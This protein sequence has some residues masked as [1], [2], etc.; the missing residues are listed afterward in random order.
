MELVVVNK[1]MLLRQVVGECCCSCCCRPPKDN[2]LSRRLYFTLHSL[3][4]MVLIVSLRNINA[5]SL[6]EAF[7]SYRNIKS[8]AVN[9]AAL[10]IRKL[11]A[12][13]SISSRMTMR[14]HS[15]LFIQQ[16][17]SVQSSLLQTRWCLYSKSHTDGFE[18]FTRGNQLR[19][20]MTSRSMTGTTANIPATT[21]L[22]VHTNIR[23]ADI[24]EMLVGGERYS[25]VP[26][27]N[28]M[29]ATTIFVGNLCEFVQDSD[30]STYFSQVSSLTSVPSCV[31]RKVD[32][33]SMGYGFV[34]FPNVQE[35]EVNSF[36]FRAMPLY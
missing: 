8:G 22:Q 9:T 30:L 25:L 6:L 31:V 23:D 20:M 34:S 27:P 10:E 19:Q 32:T 4:L 28:A 21:Q 33:Q 12:A 26:M 5:Y 36:C 11:T 3:T 15:S 2:R 24:V 14:R 7:Y 18:P 17:P 35:K 1:A 16:R 13:V 29:K